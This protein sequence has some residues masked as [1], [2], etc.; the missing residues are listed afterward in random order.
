MSYRVFVGDVLYMERRQFSA[1][2][3]AFHVA[4][5]V[6]PA[7]TVTLVDQSGAV[8]RKHTAS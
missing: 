2:I 8:L 7:E 5:R 6:Y 3:V 1:I 4:S